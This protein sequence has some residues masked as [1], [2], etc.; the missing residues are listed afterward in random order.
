LT[1]KILGN[2]DDVVIELCF[3]LLEGTR[4]VCDLYLLFLPLDNLRKCI[5]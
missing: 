5:G 4:F 1:T 3:N 2:E